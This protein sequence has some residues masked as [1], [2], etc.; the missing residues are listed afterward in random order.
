MSVRSP[1]AKR[2]LKRWARTAL[3]RGSLLAGVGW[4][5]GPTPG[6]RILTYHR[7]VDD[8]ADPFAVAPA[9]FAAQ[10]EQVAATGA[11]APLDGALEAIRRGE[12]AR[13]RIALTFDDG[14]V[15]FLTEAFPVLL[16]LGLPAALYVSPARVGEPAFLDWGALE[17][18]CAAGVQI[19][20]HGLDHRS[21]GRIPPEEVRS[22]L[23]ESRRRLEDRL[24]IAVSSLAYPYGTVRDFNEAVKE[25]AR[26]V[27]YAS[28]CTS[29]NGI[30]GSSTDPLE[31]RRTKIEQ[32][33]D[34]IFQRILAG[35][36]D[37]WAFL[38]RNLSLLQN[39]Y[40]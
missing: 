18:L 17:A 7:I 28:A 13:P 25:V 16:R 33:D 38:D 29:V 27:G 37:G 3:A 9:L 22:Q 6:L 2:L 24:H 11:A 12:D 26:R 39:R 1:A 35:G 10:M 4:D 23:S 21:L 34:A 8:P 14:T 30:N 20:S 40:A 5:G 31:L 19:G 36:L 32:A 15:D